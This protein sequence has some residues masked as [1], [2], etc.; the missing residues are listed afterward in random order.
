MVGA[1]ACAEGSTTDDDHSAS[2]TNLQGASTERASTEHRASCRVQASATEPRAEGPASG[3]FGPDGFVAR[4]RADCDHD[5]HDHDDIARQGA[6]VH[7]GTVG[8]GRS[9]GV[10][11]PGMEGS[12]KVGFGPCATDEATDEAV[13]ASAQASDGF[14]PKEATASALTN[15][16]FGPEATAAAAFA[17]DGVG[18]QAT[19][20]EAVAAYAGFGPCAATRSDVDGGLRDH[21]LRAHEEVDINATIEGLGRVGLERGGGLERRGFV[22]RGFVRSSSSSTRCGCSTSGG[23]SCTSGGGSS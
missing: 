13:A 16:G 1:A 4:F 2:C 3:G 11:P 21:V 8:F 9:G 10:R 14:G 7:Q 5:V 22:R 12:W 20:S 18:H 15:D 17:I 19:A 23:S 6:A